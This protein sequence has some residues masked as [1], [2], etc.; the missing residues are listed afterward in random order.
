MKKQDELLATLKTQT[1]ELQQAIKHIHQG[2]PAQEKKKMIK[3]SDMKLPSRSSK[4]DANKSSKRKSIISSN[5]NNQVK[6]GK[7][8][9]S[10]SSSPPPRQVQKGSATFKQ[11]LSPGV[12]QASGNKQL[13]IKTNQTALPNINV[14]SDGM[15]ENVSS[16]QT[17]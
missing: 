17:L 3:L 16:I 8:E 5:I 1:K 4:L 11:V 2:P 15:L 10:E 6:T 7:M 9:K 14:Q 12:K 13:E